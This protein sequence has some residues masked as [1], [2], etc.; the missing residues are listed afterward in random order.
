[1]ARHTDWLVEQLPMVLRADPFL[2][3][4]LGIIQEVADGIQVHAENLTDIVD[5]T[6]TTSEMVRW[7]GTWVGVDNV[8]P[9]LSDER[10]R[11]LV[12]GRGRLLAWRGTRRGLQALLELITGAAVA[13]TDTGRVVAAGEPVSAQPFVWVDVDRLDAPLDYMAAVVAAELP[14][15]V[16]FVVRVDGEAVWIDDRDG[17]APPPEVPAVFNLEPSPRRRLRAPSRPRP[18]P[19]PAG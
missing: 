15:D 10:Q 2:C 11:R 14:P 8:D 3:D 7:I 5:V 1:M 17:A 9:S 13:I 4:F 12:R 19:T 16:G 18:R 6:V